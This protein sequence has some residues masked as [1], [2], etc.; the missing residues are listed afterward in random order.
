MRELE[1]TLCKKREGRQSLQ[2]IKKPRRV[3]RQ[4]R[5][6]LTRAEY[7][8]MRNMSLDILRI[9]AAQ[10]RTI[11]AERILRTKAV[12]CRMKNRFALSRFAAVD[13]AVGNIAQA[14]FISAEHFNQKGPPNGALR[15]L[16][17]TQNKCR[18]KASAF[19]LVP[20]TGVEPARPCGQRIL[21]PMRLP[22]T[23]LRHIRF[24]A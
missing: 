23:P 5:A 24:F 22:I 6:K 14:E 16:G 11:F 8:P 12:E 7:V 2:R 10:S 17:K 15:R 20:E 1:H 21:S 4:K 19:V 18:G 9:G 13:V 3:R